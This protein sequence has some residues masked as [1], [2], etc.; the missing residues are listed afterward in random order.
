MQEKTVALLRDL[1]L[2]NFPTRAGVGESAPHPVFAALDLF[3]FAFAV[4]FFGVLRSLLQTAIRYPQPLFLVQILDSW[5]PKYD[6]LFQLLPSFCS[7]LWTRSLL[8]FVHILCGCG[9]ALFRSSST[10]FRPHH[11]KTLFE[12]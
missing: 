6:C 5:F 10:G 3:A 7:K 11:P 8:A 12:S 9:P 2:E 4:F 1:G